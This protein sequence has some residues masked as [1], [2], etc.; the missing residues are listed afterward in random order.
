MHRAGADT[1]RPGFFMRL[2]TAIPVS[3]GFE[4]G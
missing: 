2:A 3:D 4:D 1:I